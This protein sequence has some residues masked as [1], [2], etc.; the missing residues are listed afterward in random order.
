[1]TTP[2]AEACAVRRFPKTQNFG[3]AN[4]IRPAGRD[5]RIGHQH[6]D[7][8]RPDAAGHRRDRAGARR[9]LGIGDIADEA[10][11]RLARRVQ[12]FGGDAIDADVDDDG[13]SAIQSPRTSSGW[14]TAATRISA[15]RATAGRSRVREWAI[16]TVQFCASSNC[17]IGLPTMF[18][19]PMMTASLPDSVRPSAAQ[20]CSIRIIAPAGVQ[21]RSARFISPIDA[22][23]TLIGMEAVDVLMRRDRL[24]DAAAH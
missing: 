3:S 24:E 15:R 16:V 19:R 18:E 2:T 12:P 13:A 22:S 9:R 17:A 11:L 20:A 21:G 7:R 1:M 14:P 6:G 23:P 5:Q 10:G 4:A 8:H